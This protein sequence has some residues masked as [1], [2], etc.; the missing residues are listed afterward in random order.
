MRIEIERQLAP[1]SI[2]VFLSLVFGLFILVFSVASGKCMCYIQFCATSSHKSSKTKGQE[3]VF[4]L[5]CHFC[6]DL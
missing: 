1:Y 2:H 3:C 6:K 4:S 5:V